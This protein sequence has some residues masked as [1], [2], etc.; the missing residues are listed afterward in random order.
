MPKKIKFDRDLQID[1]PQSEWKFY[2]H[3]YRFAFNFFVCEKSLKEV[4][5]GQ[6]LHRN[7]NKIPILLAFGGLIYQ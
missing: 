2:N 5:V 3:L 6:L 7:D 1:D 4:V